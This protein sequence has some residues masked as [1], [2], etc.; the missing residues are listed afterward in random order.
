MVVFLNTGVEQQG[1]DLTS[2]G[3]YLGLVQEYFYS[4]PI[5]KRMT[6]LAIVNHN[7]NK[8]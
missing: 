4:W 7:Q 1:V 2:M 5:R 6:K 3:L 8:L